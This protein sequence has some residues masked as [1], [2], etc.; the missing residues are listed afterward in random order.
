MPMRTYAVSAGSF[1]SRVP[2]RFAA[3]ADTAVMDQT[4][5][6]MVRG[7][8]Q[9]R[10]VG[11]ILRDATAIEAREKPVN[12]KR[13]VAQERKEPRKRGRPG[14]GYSAQIN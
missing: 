13:E 3:F 11:H 8:L 7:H 14:K 10:I 5:N 2:R 4:L 6:I 9:D 1:M 12:T